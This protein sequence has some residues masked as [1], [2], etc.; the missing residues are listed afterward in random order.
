MLTMI[1]RSWRSWQ[2]AK[3]VAIL[4]IIALATGIGCATAIFTVVDAVMLKPLPYSHP[5]R[6][7]ALF[8][9]STLGSEA[10]QIS[11][12]SISDLMD[13]QQRTHSFDMFGWY[14]IGADFNISSSGLVEHIE[15]AEI[16]SS[17]LDNAGI[18]PILGH[19]FQDSDGAHVAVISSRLWNRL[20]SDPAIVGKSITLNGQPYT[21]TG[22]MPAW[23]QVPSVTV[24]NTDFHNDV[25][26]PVNIPTDEATRRSYSFY[27]AYA[28]L[29]PGVTVAQARADAKTV[30]A[31][32][33]KENPDSSPSYTA[34]L[35]GLQDFIAKR[36]R[37]YLLLFIAAAVLL[38]L[39]TCANVAGLLVARS[40]GRAHEIAVRIALGA[41]RSHLAMQFFLEGCFISIAAAGLGLLA[42]IGLTRLVLSF[43]AEYIPRAAEISIN[44]AVV[45]FIVLLACF[46]AALPALAPLWQAVRT[47]PNEVL[48]NGARASAGARTRRLSRSLVIAE[49]A[50]AFLLLAVSGL[51]I[52][53]LE[54]LRRT[55]PGFDPSHLLTFQLNASGQETAS[56]KAF[57]AYQDRLLNSIQAL[58]GVSD[59]AFA[60]QLP[61]A[62]CCFI[63]TFRPEGQPS[64]PDS[65]QWVSYM[66]VS[67]SYFRAMRIPLAEGRLLNESDVNES[68]IPVVID[69][70][71]ARRYWPDRDP[72][73][74]F[75]RM[76]TTEEARLQVVGI[77]GNV[78]NEGLGEAT[79]PEI[80]FLNAL[81][82]IT[83]MEFVVRSV[84][85]AAS[86]LPAIQRSIQAID[87]NRAIYEVRSMD[88]IAADSI[89]HQRLDSV[90]IA[91]FALAAFLM[92]S[93][94]IYGVTSYSV[95]ERTVEI[96]TRM[97]LGALPRD[98]LNLVVGDGLRMAA[99]GILIGIPVAAGATW[100]VVRFLNLHRIGPLPFVS[101]AA[102]VG[103][104]A[105]I[106]SFFPAW[107]ATLLSPMVAIR[108][109]SESLWDVSR[110]TIEHGLHLDSRVTTNSLLD[111][112]ILSGFIDASRSADS[113][114]QALAIAIADLRKDLRSQSVM[115]FENV[116]AS[117]SQYHFRA[118]S[119]ES[120][121]AGA[122]PADGF[123]LSRL[124]FHATPLSFAADEMD[125]VLRWSHEQRPQ[126]LPEIEY[127]KAIGLRLAIPLRTKKEII[128][129]L[130][131]GPTLEGNV[132]S[133]AD[134][135]LIQACAQ[136]LA[137]MIEN[138]RLTDRVVEQEK[139]RRDVA[140]AA[141]VQERLLPEKSIEDGLSSIAAFTLPARGVG[142][143]CYDFVELGDR[144]IGVA[145][146]DV[147]GKGIAAA[148]IMAAIQASLRIF[149]SENEISPAE[150]AA[151]M[152]AFLY[153]STGFD[154]YATF[155]YAQFHS[156]KRQLRY[157]NAGHN[158][159]FLA[160]ASSSHLPDGPSHDSVEEL[161][162]GGT[163]IGMFPTADYEEA[164]VELRPGDV[165]LAFTDG[166]TEALNP[167]Q[168]E[169]GADRLK[170]L[171]CRVAH[172]PVKDIISIISSEL[173]A[174]IADAPQHDDL[175]FIV[176]K[177]NESA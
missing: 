46:T 112:T 58:P 169:F 137:L 133:L 116:S 100:L 131:L 12:L 21:V 32:I 61:L 123:L 96:G 161:T 18:N 120:S 45:L 51:L 37:P 140:L 25:W 158:P 62:G 95:R 73:G 108:N 48:A 134:K 3:G 41:R 177:I 149:A 156:Q 55:S 144:G 27:A 30:A 9:G 122:I 97:A 83:Q 162:I 143:D 2:N 176:A 142:G 115:L 38:L 94:G 167:S 52:S 168:D 164:L 33:L 153:R 19:L 39:V 128:G 34:T 113:F 31:E 103:G 160:R 159:P 11:G 105:A 42:S 85:P 50:F 57:L 59:A 43:A 126:Y 90:V 78:R 40:A 91:F 71:A 165:M 175:T 76:G 14:K 93:L 64:N 129:L 99:Y 23:F 124:K 15:G 74:S 104:V 170:S 145:L 146:A 110:R 69:E 67:P 154:R 4:A 79:R 77:V 54:N 141:E 117:D 92:A 17:L 13:Y 44:G 66:V 157:V 119:P 80:Y 111:P 150:L 125:T 65:E 10:D 118:A 49:I 163:V 173:R 174:W 29:K 20:G 98:L 63:T 5:D 109:E 172:L 147:S 155:F 127:L 60:N 53:E 132:Y 106:A 56:T 8:G 47:P 102:L 87:P 148:L 152:N 28:T 6:W 138:A 35:F 130:L 16:T 151:R 121:L 1:S 88:T 82:P 89:T 84:L 75:A 24:S 72:I 139:V 81:A 36:I 26:I 107:R 171:L 22:V 114:S 68:L 101:S 136:Q 166:V 86:L 70:A 7:V 135:E